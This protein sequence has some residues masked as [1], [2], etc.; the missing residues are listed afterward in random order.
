MLM[1]GAQRM[2]RIAIGYALFVLVLIGV[3]DVGGTQASFGFVT[4]WPYGDKLGHFGLM[5]LLALLADLATGQRDLRAPAAVAGLVLLEE[6]SQLWLPGRRSFDLGDLLADA[7]GIVGF[8]AL[9]RHALHEKRTRHASS[10]HARRA[11]SA[12]DLPSDPHSPLVPRPD[13]RVRARQQRT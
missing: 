5:G 7:L 13:E 12:H 11:A 6:L 4:R 3:A 10:L 8:M 9:G 1:L 2:R